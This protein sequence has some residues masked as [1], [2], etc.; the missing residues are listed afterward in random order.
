MLTSSGVLSY[1]GRLRC[2]EGN[3]LGQRLLSMAKHASVRLPARFLRASQ[4]HT[5]SFS[6]YGFKRPLRP[7]SASSGPRLNGTRVFALPL[8]ESDPISGS[9]DEV[10]ALEPKFLSRQ[11]IPRVVHES[12]SR[13]RLSCPPS[14]RPPPD[15]AVRAYTG[16]LTLCGCSVPDG[17]RVV[18]CFAKICLTP[19]PPPIRRKADPMPVP[20]DSRRLRR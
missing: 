3:A 11:R 5:V 6:Q 2:S 12:F 19:W 14:L 15:F 1:K 10:T 16:G 7:E 4:F 20:I 18:P 8:P 17:P 13:L 9:P